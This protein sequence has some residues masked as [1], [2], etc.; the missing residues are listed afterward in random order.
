MKAA[1][2]ALAAGSQ[3]KFW[4]FHDLLFEN[5]NKLNDRKIEAIVQ[6]LGLDELEFEKSVKDPVLQRKVRQDL[7]DGQQAGVKGTP[8]VFINGRLIMDMTLRGFQTAIDKELKKIG[9]NDSKPVSG[10]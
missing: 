9:K 6:S 5:Y 1:I 3:G 7:L 8:T 2:S 10:N 4:E